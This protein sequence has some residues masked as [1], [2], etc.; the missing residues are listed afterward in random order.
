[1]ILQDRLPHDATDI[2][3]LPGVR[4]L[5]GDWLLVDEAY[6]AQM[7]ERARLIEQCPQAVH[8][9]DPSARPAADELLETV[10]KHLPEGFERRGGQMTRPDGMVV[11]LDRVNPLLALGGLVQEDLCLMLARD[12]VHVLAGAILCFPAHWR[13]SDK[14]MRPLV[15]IHAPVPSYDDNIGARVQRLF[16][17]IQPGR[18]LW[19]FN[20]LWNHDPTLFQPKPRIGPRGSDATTAPYLR[21]E[22]QCLLRLPQSRAVV[23]SIHTYVVAR[24]AVEGTAEFR[25]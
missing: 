5:T 17:G 12:D 1:M 11:T 25:A 8:A 7:A 6:G 2:R 23:F 18:P 20:T 13:L 22:R 4:P 21:S 10:L 19:R 15:A 24:A 16:H 14:F 3:P 9:L